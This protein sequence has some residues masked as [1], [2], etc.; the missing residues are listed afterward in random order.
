VRVAA[1]A[2]GNVWARAE[3]EKKRVTAKRVK[4]LKRRIGALN[5]NRNCNPLQGESICSKIKMRL[6]HGANPTIGVGSS[7]VFVN[8]YCSDT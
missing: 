5:F 1:I 4:A 6:K 2:G 3:A 7:A 8:C